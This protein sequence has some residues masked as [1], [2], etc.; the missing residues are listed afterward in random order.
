M[1][2][3]SDNCTDIKDMDQKIVLPTFSIILKSGLWILQT[4]SFG[5]RVK[6]EAALSLWSMIYPSS[7]VSRKLK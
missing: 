6:W 3:Y 4:Q 5:S 2:E 7:D 1:L